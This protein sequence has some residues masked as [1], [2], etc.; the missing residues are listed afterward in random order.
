M[1]VVDDVHLAAGR[2]E[3]GLQR[4]A[5]DP[6]HR[7]Q[8][9]LQVGSADGVHVHLVDDRVDVAVER[10]DLA[11]QSPR[12]GLVVGHLPNP[13]LAGALEF[14]HAV[15]DVARDHFVR[16]PAARREHFDP[17][18]EGGV[19]GGRYGHAVGQPEVLDGPH[20][21]RGGGLGD[22][23]HPARHP[24]PREHLCRPL[25]GDIG[26][27]S[28]VVADN[29]P[30]VLVSL[31]LDAL[32]ERPAEQS[33]VAAGEFVT[34]DRPPAAGAEVDARHGMALSLLLACAQRRQF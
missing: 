21:Q 20:D 12:D 33:H 6:E 13:G 22:P 26:E 28:P 3:D 29:D 24:L 4:G 11:D 2:H 34:D 10:I 15:L 27:E 7:V 31:L 25:G 19:V 14:R 32:G 8:C 23:D 18:V 1:A 30:L 5:R 9:D 17:V 16:V